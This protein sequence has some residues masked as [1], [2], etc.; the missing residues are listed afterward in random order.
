MYLPADTRS[1]NLSQTKIPTLHEQFKQKRR[2]IFSY[3]VES[4]VIAHLDLT[5][6]KSKE[7]INELIVNYNCSVDML[8]NSRHNK[9]IKEN[10]KDLNKSN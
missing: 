10:K 2:I 6:E 8:P 7:I 4:R 3:L 9:P 5:G 1:A